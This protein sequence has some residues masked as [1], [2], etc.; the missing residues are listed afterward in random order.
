MNKKFTE[1]N[2]S[3]NP[4]EDAIEQSKRKTAEKI[5]EFPKVV[6]MN[7]IKNKINP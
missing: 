7:D 1:T 5:I 3:I 4:W 6:K 2:N